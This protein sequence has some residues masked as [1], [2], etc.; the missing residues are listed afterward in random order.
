MICSR[1][2]LLRLNNVVFPEATGKE[3]CS[4]PQSIQTLH[5]IS[6]HC[7]YALSPNSCPCQSRASVI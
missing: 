2:K 6:M 5:L 1:T 7:S 4:C 3:M